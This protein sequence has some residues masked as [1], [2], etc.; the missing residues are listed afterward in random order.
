L[1]DFDALY[2][3]HTDPEVMRF[4][5][6]PL[7][8][9]REYA[10]EHYHRVVA[11]WDTTNYACFHAAL[12]DTDEF[13]GWAGFSR[14]RHVDGIH[15]GFRF[16]REFWGQGYATEAGRAIARASFAELPLEQLVSTVHSDNERVHRL[17]ERL[18][19]SRSGPLDSRDHKGKIVLYILQRNEADSTT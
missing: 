15:L 9:S 4:V 8:W 10:L 17:L 5:G 14:D 11:N 3:M 2:V 18:G 19:F 7:P 6:G 16:R 1:G 12:Q 13:V